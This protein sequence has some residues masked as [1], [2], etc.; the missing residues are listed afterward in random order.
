MLTYKKGCHTVTVSHLRVTFVSM[1][2]SWLVISRD[3]C[4]SS[5][6]IVGQDLLRFSMTAEAERD[7]LS[8]LLICIPLP[9]VSLLESL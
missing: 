4:F 2:H 9:F 7:A 5:G 3:A 8:A 1:Y 6:D